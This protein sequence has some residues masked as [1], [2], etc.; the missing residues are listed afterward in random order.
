MECYCGVTKPESQD[1]G[2]TSGQGAGASYNNGCVLCN[3]TK[4][5]RHHLQTKPPTAHHSPSNDSAAL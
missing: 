2:R 5:P 3:G 1:C 4:P